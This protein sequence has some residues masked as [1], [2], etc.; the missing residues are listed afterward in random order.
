MRYREGYTA[1]IRLTGVQPLEVRNPIDQEP[2]VWAGRCRQD[3]GNRPAVD[4]P[5]CN[6]QRPRPGGLA[7][8]CTV[9]ANVVFSRRKRISTLPMS[10][11]RPFQKPSRADRTITG[12]GEDEVEQRIDRIISA[13][14][15][16]RWEF[17]EA[18]P[19]GNDL[20]NFDDRRCP[21]LP[22]NKCTMARPI[23]G[24]LSTRSTHRPRSTTGLDS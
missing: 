10:P 5:L 13:R 1:L 8:S 18:V 15:W 19:I 17:E 9:P 24:V 12:F 3:A 21:S 22:L 14:R 7:P 4:G 11:S 6:R 16:H 2:A 23:I 20:C